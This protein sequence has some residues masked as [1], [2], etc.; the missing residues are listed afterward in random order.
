MIKAFKFRAQVIFSLLEKF[1][2]KLS[3]RIFSLFYIMSTQGSYIHQKLDTNSCFAKLRAN[4]Y[5]FSFF[6][7]PVVVLF[8]KVGKCNQTTDTYTFK[9]SKILQISLQL[10]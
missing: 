4:S 7:H 5:L 10:R 6:I 1:V 2:T 3:S 8:P 9:P